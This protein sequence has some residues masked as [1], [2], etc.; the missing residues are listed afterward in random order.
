MAR[1]MNS[2]FQGVD[3][4]SGDGEGT[5]RKVEGKSGACGVSEAK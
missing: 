1:P 4:R 2:R 5:I 3:R